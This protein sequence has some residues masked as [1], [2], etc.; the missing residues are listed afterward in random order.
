MAGIEECFCCRGSNPGRPDEKSRI[1]IVQPPRWWKNV[2]CIKVVWL[3]E[4]ACCC[5][6]PNQFVQKYA[7]LSKYNETF[8]LLF[9]DHCCWIRRYFLLAVAPEIALHCWMERP[10][11]HRWRWRVSVD[12]D[13]SDGSRRNWYQIRKH[14]L[15]KFCTCFVYFPNDFCLL[16]V[17]FLIFVP[18][19]TSY[20][21][22]FIKQMF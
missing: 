8:S 18:C 13:G 16:Y 4:V 5:F 6:R 3:R 9:P 17:W 11:G 12:N 7:S 15:H 14:L 1:T 10:N 19:N 21:C 22:W 2:T 20:F